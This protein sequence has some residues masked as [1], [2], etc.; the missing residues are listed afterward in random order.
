MCA[1]QYRNEIEEQQG[2]IELSGFGVG[3]RV[4]GQ[5]QTVNSATLRNAGYLGTEEVL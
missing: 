1:E 4:G 5:G 2:R 3:C